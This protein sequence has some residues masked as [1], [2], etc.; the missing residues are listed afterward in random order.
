MET[1]EKKRK[2]HNNGTG[3]TYK[4]GNTWAFEIKR[5]YWDGI[6]TQ[7]IV[8]RGS[9]FKTKTEADKARMAMVPEMEKEIEERKHGKAVATG[10]QKITFKELGKQYLDV[11]VSKLGKK[12]IQNMHRN[13]ELCKDLHDL[14]WDSITVP[15]FQKYVDLGGT[16][17][18]AKKM[19]QL[20]T[21]MENFALRLNLTAQERAKLCELPKEPIPEKAT[22]SE[23]E[24][25]LLWQVQ[26]RVYPYENLTEEDY[27]ACAALLIM[28][29]TGMRPGELINIRPEDI[30]FTTGKI[31]KGGIKT[32]RGKTGSIF[33]NN[34]I[35]PVIRQYMVPVNQFALVSIES[36]RARVNNLLDTLGMEHHVLS[37]CR[38]TTATVLAEMGTSE[39]DLKTIMRHTNIAVTRKYYDKS[40]DANAQKALE[41]FGAPVQPSSNAEEEQT[42]TLTFTQLD[43]LIQERIAAALSKKG[44]SA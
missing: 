25:N 43:M 15:E 36:T 1:K 34:K 42:I 38:T 3:T 4:R 18:T 37:A 21:G 8:K 28:L 26:Q 11:H 9:G 31:C 32:V 20:L 30:D 41:R 2:A 5:Q 22:F 10:K 13:F 24:R 39:D 6:K 7:S 16:Y 29:H 35:A 14:P 40:G 27:M 19:K 23:E 44:Y 12:T 17:D 33:I